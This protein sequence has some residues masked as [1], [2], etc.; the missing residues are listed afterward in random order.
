MKKFDCFSPTDFRYSVE[1]LKDY[2]TEDAFIKYKTIVEVALIRKLAEYGICPKDIIDEVEKASEK[3]YTKEV[4]QKEEELKHDIRALV[5]IIKSKVS[6]KAKLY[7]HL[8]ATSYDIINIANILRYKNAFYDIILP[9]MVKLERSLIEMARNEKNTL[10]MGRTHGQHAEPLTFGFF[11]AQYVNRW[12]NMILKVKNAINNLVGKFSG[13]IGAYNALSLFLDNPEKFEYDLLKSL[14][15]KSSKISTQILPPE[16]LINLIHT[17]VLGWGVLANYADDM[18]NLQRTE[19]GEV[20]ESFDVK[21]IGSSTM[22]QKRNPINFENIKSSWKKFMPTMITLYLNQIIEHQGDLTNSLSS[23]Y[24]P[25]L[26]VIFDSSVKRAINVTKNLQINRDKMK[27]NFVQSADKIIAEPLQ[28]LLSQSGYS[29]AYEKVRELTIVSN[30]ES[31]SLIKLIFEDKT[32]KPYL[33]KFNEN[34]IKLILHPEN[35]IGIAPKKTAEICDLW[36]RLIINIE[37]DVSE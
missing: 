28:I 35:Y 5:E 13:S 22:P 18:R 31:K 27:K 34:H 19:I 25:E 29:N 37:D 12:G 24:L 14:G 10:Q 32:I 16:P 2:L 33:K 9:D 8:T 4:Y 11:I 26:F 1:E 7:I 15:L 20:Y 23:R 6:P 17:V 21:Q 36:E 30:Q 3:I